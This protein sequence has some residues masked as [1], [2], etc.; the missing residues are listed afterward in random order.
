M[1]GVQRKAAAR[2]IFIRIKRVRVIGS[3]STIS[4]IVDYIRRPTTRRYTH[5]DAASFVSPLETLPLFPRC[6]GRGSWKT[7]SVFVILKRGTFVET[8]RLPTVTLILEELA[9]PR[10]FTEPDA[11]RHT[12]GALCDVKR[13]GG[14]MVKLYAFLR[15]RG[16]TLLAKV[17][18]RVSVARISTASDCTFRSSGRNKRD[19]RVKFARKQ[20]ALAA[21]RFA[22]FA[23]R[24]RDRDVKD[25]AT[26]IVGYS[27]RRI[28]RARMEP[29]ETLPARDKRWLASMG[30][31]CLVEKGEREDE[32]LK[33][34]FINQTICN[35]ICIY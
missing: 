30:R 29:R 34:L 5:G 8:V 27:S 35:L 3:R 10:K 24:R 32:F 1:Y 25:R 9:S 11:T 19:A 2:L 31:L 28:K 33:F 14:G 15:G 22:R 21:N 23:R 26:G 13:R 4:N 17:Y 20:E 7:L 6:V 12:L 16:N 18:Q